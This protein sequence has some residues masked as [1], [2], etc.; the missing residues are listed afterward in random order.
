MTRRLSHRLL[1]IAPAVLLLQSLASAGERPDAS[2]LGGDAPPLATER[3]AGRHAGS[4]R[5]AQGDLGLDL[6]RLHQRV[7]EDAVYDVFPKASK[8]TSTPSDKDPARPDH[9]LAE[10]SPMIGPVPVPST[11]P[12]PPVPPAPP[13]ST[14][15][16][17]VRVEEKP[18]PPPSPPPLPMAA[19][20]PAVV[21]MAVRVQPSDPPKVVAPAPPD[22]PK[23]IVVSPPPPTPAFP[24]KYVGKQRLESGRTI[25]FLTKDGKLYTIE[26]GQVLDQLYS[27]DGEEG[28]Q[29]TVTYLP[30]NRQQTIH[31]GSPS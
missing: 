13:A 30:F 23:P 1:V 28:G 14:G 10:P 18:V 7:T 3:T 27:I 21:P 11:R 2:R 25:Y 5:L 24:F 16:P 12:A 8:P 9:R 22:P 4:V 29:L 20:A 15:P 6:Q 31:V 19:P 26:V 17:A